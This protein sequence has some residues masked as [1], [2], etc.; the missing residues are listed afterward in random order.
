MNGKRFSRDASAAL[1]IMIFM[2]GAVVLVPGTWAASKYRTLHKFTGGKNGSQPF[3]GL[4]FDSSGALYGTTYVGGTGPCLGHGC[5]VVFKLSPNANGR[6]REQV[7]HR[8]SG[9]DGSNPQTASLILDAQGNLFGTTEFGGASGCDGNGCGVAFELIPNGDGSWTEKVLHWFTGNVGVNPVANLIFDAAGNLYGT[10]SDWSNGFTG[11]GV[12]FE[13]SPNPDGSWTESILH[14]FDNEDGYNPSSGV[15]FDL[16]GNLYGT[17]IYGGEYNNG[18][19]YRLS[20]N[21]D[22]SWTESVLHSFTGGDDGFRPQPGLIRDPAS[23]LYGVTAFGGPYGY[24]TVFQLT[25]NPDGSWTHSNLYAFQGGIDGGNPLARLTLAG[26]GTLYGTTHDHGAYGCGVV[27][28]LTAALDGKWNEKVIRAFKNQPACES[29]GDLIIDPAG[30]LYGTT[31]GDGM[32]T[33][34][35]VFTITP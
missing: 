10:T 5:G 7:L 35:S 16:D 29:F 24:G 30:N 26:P 34:G 20:P 23:P 28:K 2:L 3:S 18:V 4:V 6:W 8:F 21:L 19:V 31:T 12:V 27:F 13:L 15:I 14:I 11:P 33:F 32:K 25:P 22:G 1:M 17:T 9:E